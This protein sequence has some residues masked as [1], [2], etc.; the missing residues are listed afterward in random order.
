MIDSVWLNNNSIAKNSFNSKEIIFATNKRVV[1]LVSLCF[2]PEPSGSGFRLFV[3][4]WNHSDSA[5]HAEH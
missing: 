1:G 5:A 3:Y 2:Y 4:S